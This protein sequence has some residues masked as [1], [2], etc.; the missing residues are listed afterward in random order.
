MVSTQWLKHR[1]ISPVRRWQIGTHQGSVGWDHLTFYLDEFSFRFNR[2]TSPR[3]A[4]TLL[5]HP[6]GQAHAPSHEGPHPQYQVP[7]STLSL[8]RP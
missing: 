5:A 1:V 4:D 6:P 2:R 3:V 7:R 8:A